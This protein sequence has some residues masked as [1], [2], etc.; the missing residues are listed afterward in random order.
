MRLVSKRVQS[1]RYDPLD[2]VSDLVAFATEIRS[3]D[4]IERDRTEVLN[5][6]VEAAHFAW[7]VLK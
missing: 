3:V 7:E 1:L 6:L 5:I 4:G 2:F